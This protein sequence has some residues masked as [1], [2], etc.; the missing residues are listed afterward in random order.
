MLCYGGSRS[1]DH[2]IIKV[3]RDLKAHRIPT[4]QHLPLDQLAPINDATLEWSKNSFKN[5]FCTQLQVLEALKKPAGHWCV[6]GIVNNA[7]KLWRGASE[8]F[9]SPWPPRK[10]CAGGKIR[11]SEEYLTLGLLLVLMIFMGCFCWCSQIIS[12]E[13]SKVFYSKVWC[14]FFLDLEWFMGFF[15]AFIKCH[16][17]GLLW[18]MAWTFLVPVIPTYPSSLWP[19]TASE[20]KPWTVLELQMFIP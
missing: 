16:S 13:K 8:G 15:S 1:K 7:V 12:V 2:R 18:C 3:G 10:C 20:N 9:P 5:L 17:C 4:P 19:V 14:C 11:H 6:K